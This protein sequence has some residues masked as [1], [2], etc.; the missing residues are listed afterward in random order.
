M[1]I[2]DH[3]MRDHCYVKRH[4]IEIPEPIEEMVVVDD[5]HVSSPYDTV[6]TVEISSASDTAVTT[7]HGNL[8][9]HVQ[10]F[11]SNE[12]SYSPTVHPS[13]SPD[14]SLLDPELD[15]LLLG[16]SSENSDYEEKPVINITDL[17]LGIESFH[18]LNVP[19]D[20]VDKSLVDVNFED[21]QVEEFFANANSLSD[22][23]N[24]HF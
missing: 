17:L 23:D 18:D 14:S 1:K 10:E 6:E 12:G 16:N 2:E 24:L 5:V 4:D 19:C 7:L 21:F 20:N 9:P 13:G 22:M 8:E 3:V 15:E 11:L